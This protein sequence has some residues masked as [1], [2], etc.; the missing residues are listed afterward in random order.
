MTEHRQEACCDEVCENIAKSIKDNDP[1]TAFSIIRRI[2]GGS[3][4][5]EKVPADDKTGKIFVNS[6]DT[7]KR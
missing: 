6:R 7:L 2:R 5:V 4:R 1:A 3:K